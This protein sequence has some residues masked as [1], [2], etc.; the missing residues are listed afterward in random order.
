M[1]K[2]KRTETRLT[3]TEQRML[4][5]IVHKWNDARVKEGRGAPRA[6]ESEVMLHA[7]HCFF[8]AEFPEMGKR[9]GDAVSE[10]RENHQKRYG[11][12]DTVEK[13]RALLEDVNAVS[14]LER[15]AFI[16]ELEAKAGAR[17]D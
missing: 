4:R 1:A 11:E 6:T 10:V 16:D 17:S 2:T 7:L 3:D 5:A 12:P 8:S 9:I 13:L 14:T 15:E